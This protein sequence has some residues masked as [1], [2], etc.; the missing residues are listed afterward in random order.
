MA[1]TDQARPLSPRSN[2]E[3][4]LETMEDMSIKN[5][6]IASFKFDNSTTSVYYRGI[7]VAD[8]QIPSGLAK[9][10]KTLHLNVPV[11]IMANRLA[12]SPDLLKDVL[13]G[14]MIMNTY[15][16]LSGIAKIW[17]IKKDVVVDMNCTM[18]IN[19]SDRAIQDINC[20]HKVIL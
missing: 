14:K 8:A 7:L 9:A 19:I 13:E 4:A 11:V 5:P 10:R 18:T 15:S 2:E 1:E 12:S 20:Q 6:N 17:F 16:I 3:K